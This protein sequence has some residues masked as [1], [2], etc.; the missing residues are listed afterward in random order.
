MLNEPGLLRGMDL[1]VDLIHTHKVAAPLDPR[2]GELL[3]SYDFAWLAIRSREAA[4]I[5]NVAG[6]YVWW[7]QNPEI[8]VAEVPTA[9]DRV[10]LALASLLAGIPRNAP[11]LNHSLNALRGLVDACAGSMFLPPRRTEDL[12]KVEL[13]V[14][15]QEATSLRDALNAARFVAGDFPIALGPVLAREF[16]LP[17]LHGRKRPAEAA[18]DAQTLVDAELARVRG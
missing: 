9:G 3:E 8:F 11:D 2:T 1:L 12:Q 5:G 10:C 7:L 13:A 4:M 6:Q 18:R 17:I 14:R 15:E 16:T